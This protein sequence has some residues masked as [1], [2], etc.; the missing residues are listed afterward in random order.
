M[1]TENIHTIM[2]TIIKGS[3]KMIKKMGLELFALKTTLKNTKDI[4]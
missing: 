2:E 4:G 1:A 3:G